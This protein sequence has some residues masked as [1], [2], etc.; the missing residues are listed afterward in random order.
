M[1][2]KPTNIYYYNKVVALTSVD[3][4][5]YNRAVK[6]FYIFFYIF[7][8]KPMETKLETKRLNAIRLKFVFFERQCACCGK[9]IRLGKLWHVKRNG[10]NHTVHDWHYCQKCMPT[11]KDVLHEI[12]T[13]GIPFGISGLDDDRA[14]K[15]DATRLEEAFH[16]PDPAGNKE[17]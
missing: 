8:R 15:K 13:D 10:I 1:F 7:R 16:F 5:C 17:P 3:I 9:F 4:L 2:D 14:F 12:D 11:A 6:I